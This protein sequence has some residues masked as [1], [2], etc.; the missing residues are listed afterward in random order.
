MVDDLPPAVF[1][2][3]LGSRILGVVVYGL[4]GPVITI[5]AGVVAAMVILGVFHSVI[6]EKGNA[7]ESP[8]ALVLVLLLAGTTALVIMIWLARV[9]I[10]WYRRRAGGGSQGLARPT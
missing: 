10:R 1:R 8:L 7:S 3:P 2:T 4:A 6:P 5:V 9:M